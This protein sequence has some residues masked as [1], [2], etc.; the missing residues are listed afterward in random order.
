MA[1][2]EETYVHALKRLYRLLREIATTKLGFKFTDPTIHNYDCVHQGHCEVDFFTEDAAVLDD[3]QRRVVA[4]YVSAFVVLTIGICGQRPQLF[5]GLKYGNL[6]ELVTKGDDAQCVFP[7]G[8]EKI[9]R[10]GVPIWLDGGVVKI[11]RHVLGFYAAAVYDKP[12][13]EM[14]EQ[15]PGCLVL[16]HYG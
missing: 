16:P 12:L 10:G 4:M 3:S 11:L 8:I 14:V 2:T 5:C 7:C 1:I 13:A 6:T 15:H 9:D